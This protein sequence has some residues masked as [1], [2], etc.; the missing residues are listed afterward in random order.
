AEWQKRCEVASGSRGT[1]GYSSKYPNFSRAFFI[2]AG[3]GAL[4]GGNLSR[5]WNGRHASMIA[6]ELVKL[7]LALSSGLMRGSSGVLHA[8]CTMSIEVAGSDLVSIAH[9]R[10]SRFDTSM[11][12][13]TTTTYLPA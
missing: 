8:P 1:V 10:S 9:T 2:S 4:T 13:S 11:S 3:L 12:S 5:Q 7:P 6:R